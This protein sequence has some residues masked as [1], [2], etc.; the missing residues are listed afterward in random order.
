MYLPFGLDSTFLLLIPG[1]I[2]AIWAQMKVKSTFSKW[3]K[4]ATNQGVTGSEVARTILS[5]HG[6]DNI[7]IKPTRGR[8]TDNYNP[9][10]KTLN[11]SEPVYGSSSVAAVGVAAHEAGH[12]LQHNKNYTP[13]FVRNGIFPVARFGSWLAFPL[14]FIGFFFHQP[15][16]VKIGIYLFAGFVAFTLITLP[17]EFNAS[18]RA[19]GI[20]TN[21]GNFTKQELVGVKEV[22]SAASL[23]YV[24][25]ALMALLQLLRLLMLSGRK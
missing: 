5:N 11:L 8:L 21:S 22:L 4:V 10:K 2:I 23:T 12:A 7:P 14:F 24:A 20:L 13:L 3:S 15:S 1:I 6:L 9:V 16:M 19:V 17:V 25:S 18:R